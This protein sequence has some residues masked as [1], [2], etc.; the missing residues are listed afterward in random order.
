[1]GA[2]KL[3]TTNPLLDKNFVNAFI[4]GVST[5]MATMANCPVAPGSPYVEAGT[6]PQADVAGIIGMVNGPLRGTLALGYSTAAAL[7]MFKDMLGEEKT[8]VDSE[9]RDAIGELTNQIYGAGK[10]TLNQLGYKFEMAI[11]TVVS[12]TFTVGAGGGTPALVA[13]FTLK[14]GEKMF[15]LIA[16]QS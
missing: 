6:L 1:M 10:T 3:T 12:G 9:I 5:T 2:P 13:P 11:P 4:Q 16:V 14:G 7:R 15:I 8:A